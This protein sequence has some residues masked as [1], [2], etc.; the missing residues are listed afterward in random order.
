MIIEVPDRGR[1]ETTTTPSP[2]AGR[3]TGSVD[4]AAKGTDSTSV[5]GAKDSG[6]RWSDLSTFAVR[7]A[8]FSSR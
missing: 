3:S 7:A 1:P 2:T 5:A 6:L 8:H 4:D